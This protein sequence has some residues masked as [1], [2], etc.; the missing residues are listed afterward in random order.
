MTRRCPGGGYEHWPI[1]R[2]DLDP[3]YDAVEAMLTPSPSNRYPDLPKAKA[4][5]EAAQALGLDCPPAAGD[6][7]RADRAAG[8]LPSRSS[9]SRRTATSTAYCG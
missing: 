9:P 4:L 1:E 6:H 2:G 7:V 3:H 8:R 5:R